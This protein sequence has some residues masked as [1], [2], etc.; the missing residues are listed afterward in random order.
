MGQVLKC[1]TFLVE[2]ANIKYI[3]TWEKKKK[4]THLLTEG[5]VLNCIK[6][7]K[8]WLTAPLYLNTTEDKNGSFR[9]S[10]LTSLLLFSSVVLLVAKLDVFVLLPGQCVKDLVFG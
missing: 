5:K 7:M 8:H 9:F 10:S 1:R 3:V 2:H 4:V 6:L